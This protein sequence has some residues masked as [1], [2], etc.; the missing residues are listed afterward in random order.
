MNKLPEYVNCN[1][2]EFL[3]CDYYMCLDLCRETCLFA[4]DIMGYG[5]GGCDSDTAQ[6]ILEEEVTEVGDITRLKREV[7]ENES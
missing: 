4:R 6:R 3:V 5:V 7:N 1:N 2:Q